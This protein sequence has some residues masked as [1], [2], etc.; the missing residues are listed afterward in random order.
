MRDTSNVTVIELLP[1]LPL[2]EEM[3]FIPCTPLIACSSGM[4]TADSTVCALAPMYPLL[5]TTCGGAR[6]G[7]C[8]TGSV[9]MQIAPASTI[10]NAQTVANTGL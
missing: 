2:V 5:T 9:G 1:S 10:N 7:N 6:S 4:V 3:Y 8:A